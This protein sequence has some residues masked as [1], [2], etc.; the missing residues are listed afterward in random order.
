MSTQRPPAQRP[1]EIVVTVRE[2][3]LGDY[4]MAIVIDGVAVTGLD[5][6]R[7]LR[8]HATASDALTSA[9]H[10]VKEVT[11]E[12][13]AAMGKMVNDGTERQPPGR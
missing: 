3:P 7:V 2:K 5:S 4:S 8:H 1:K 9:R 10:A 13:P 11:K 12:R 6:D